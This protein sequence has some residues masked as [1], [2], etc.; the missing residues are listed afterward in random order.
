MD[1][2]FDGLV[3]GMDVD[4]L[5]SL[6]KAT[7]KAL[8]KHKQMRKVV[9]NT[10]YGGFALNDLGH[11]ILNYFDFEDDHEI[12]R[13]HPVLVRTLEMFGSQIYGFA[14]QK[15]DDFAIGKVELAPDEEFYI[16]EYDGWEHLEIREGIQGPV[17]STPDGLEEYLLQFAKDHNLNQ[18]P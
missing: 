10:S 18:T 4:Q 13:D 12:P 9:I 11:E 17:P 1:Y 14:T 2:N 15:C 5:M 6:R 16:H 7:S 3:K 8:A